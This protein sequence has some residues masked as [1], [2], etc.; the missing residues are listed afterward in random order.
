VLVW[1]SPVLV[2][3]A[4]YLTS[5]YSYLL[6]HTLAEMFSIV[7]GCGIF[8]LAWNA[9]RLLRNNYLLLLGIAFGCIAVLDLAH[10]LLYKGMG[11]FPEF[12]SDPPTQLWIAARSVQAISLLIAPF[13]FGRRVIPELLLGAYALVTGIILASIF[14][15]DLFP[16]C[17]VEGR[18]LTPFKKASE[19][20]ICLILAGSMAVLFRRRK[21]FDPQVLRW[22]IWAVGLTIIS[23]LAFTSY[24]DV[25]GTGNLLGHMVKIAA[26]YLIYRAII[27]TG[28]AKPQQLL[29]RQAMQSEERYRLLFD[30]SPDAIFTVSTEGRFLM[31]NPACEMLTGYSAAELTGKHVSE[32]CAPD[33]AE[34]T[35]EF[36]KTNMGQP[37]YVQ[38]ETAL[39]RKDGRRVDVW[40]AGKA[41]LSDGKAAAVHCTARDI[42]E[43]KRFQEELERL[44]QKRTA[45]LR[46]LVGEL[47]HLSYSITH[48]MRAPLRAMR[49]FAGLLQ[50]SSGHKLQGEEAEFLQRIM[51]SAERMDRLITD[52]LQYSGTVMRQMP[53]SSVKAEALLRDIIASYPDFQP[54]K[55]HV[56]I[57]GPIPDVW[58][59]PA[60][61]TQCFSN[62]LNNAIKFVQPEKIPEVRVWAET[63]PV[64]ESRAEGAPVSAERMSGVGAAEVVRIW[65]ED[66]GIGIPKVAQNRLFRMF[67]RLSH[68]QEGTGVGLA[69]VRK[70]AERMGG[71]VG[72]ESEPGKGSRFWLEFAATGIRET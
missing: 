51:S 40:V 37:H 39:C 54:P 11:L 43:R 36:F 45:S 71:V 69:L 5:R 59:N 64:P 46:E 1:G 23:E 70:T 49:G 14:A 47:E 68:D 12:D 4:L 55:S 31:V 50:E 58:A 27:E 35:I 26:F 34:R 62:L 63:K 16:A 32:I 13:L 29:L 42:G 9:R 41:L 48:D 7:I 18:G 20:V 33:Q 38:L 65:V 22:L 10:T 72:V 30:L 24:V 25:Y 28:F 66:N 44:V 21:E 19:Y 17:F 2:F 67:Q 56:S 15:F 3:A 52:A 6:F 8:M 61:L 57:I 60:G 53:L